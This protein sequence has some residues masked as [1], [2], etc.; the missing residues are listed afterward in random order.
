MTE[1]ANL[2]ARAWDL[3]SRVIPFL[4]GLM[5]WEAGGQAGVIPAF[6]LPAPTVILAKFVE[7]VSDG[8]MVFHTVE[9]LRRALFGYLAA[10]A[11]GVPAG[12][13]LGWFGRI[14]QMF[15]LPVELLRP[16]PA[17]ALVPFGILVFGIGDLSKIFV[18]FYA[19][20]FVLFIATL[21]GAANVD[22]ILLLSLRS[23]RA[24]NRYIF[25]R[26]LI[27][28]ASPY[29]FAGLRQCIAIALIL[30]IA[31]EMILGGSGLGF[32]IMDAERTF[33]ISAMYSGIFFLGLLGYTLTKLFLGLERRTLNWYKR[34]QGYQG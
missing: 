1:Q 32:F 16:I 11:V 25:R 4:G 30:M 34:D 10:V 18:I 28:A 6:L 12:L 14:Y 2:S 9:S 3:V 5:V 33:K 24:T 17:I 19:C 15:E 26:V 20:F 29:I 22:E 13:L 21:Y 23:M 27:F 8:T 31:G 7:L